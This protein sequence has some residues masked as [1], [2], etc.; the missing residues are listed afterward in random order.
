MRRSD[1]R[2][3]NQGKSSLEI[4][5]PPSR[6]CCPLPP[7]LD[8]QGYHLICSQFLYSVTISDRH[9]AAFQNSLA[10]PAQYVGSVAAVV[11]FGC[12]PLLP[13]AIH[14]FCRICPTYLSE[15]Y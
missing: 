3:P 6:V 9:I 1:V 2:T 13:R 10:S 15:Q 11:V 7:P 4:I 8:L 14:I 5:S 12:L